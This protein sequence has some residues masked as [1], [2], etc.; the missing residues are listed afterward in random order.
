[1]QL[2]GFDDPRLRQ[3]TVGVLGRGTP[4]MTVLARH[5]M[6]E[7]VRSYSLF[8]PQAVVADVAGGAIDVAILWGPLAAWWA[9]DQRV[10]LAVQPLPKA[11]GDIP[12]QFDIAIG[13][14]K[15]DEEL[16][17][18]LDAALARNRERIGNVLTR[19]HVPRFE[20]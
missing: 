14:R 13:V 1:V 8:E 4:P 9:Q 20:N 5:G 2:T 6:A 19:W 17:R 12:M 11:D 18:D 16:R 7:N 3:L 10:A 15:G